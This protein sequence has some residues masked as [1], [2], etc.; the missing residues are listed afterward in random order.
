MQTPRNQQTLRSECE[1]TGVGYWSGRSVRVRLLPGEVSTGIV[2]VRSDLPGRPACP[3]HVDYRDDA[4][5]RTN[6]VNGAARFEM[7]EH[8]LAALYAMRIDNC[9]VEIDGEEFPGLD[10]SSRAYSDAIFAAGTTIQ[11]TSRKQLIIQQMITLHDGASWITASPMIHRQ[12]HFGYQL[13]FDHPG[14]IPNQCF[15]LVCSPEDFRREVASARTFVTRTEAE[16]LQSSGVATHVSYKDLLVFGDT[17]PIDNR[18]RFANECARH[19]ALDLIGDLALAG[20]E[21]VGKFVSHRGGHRLNGRMAEA[22]HQL[23]KSS[24]VNR[25]SDVVRQRAA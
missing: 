12:S 20:V 23:A 7:V 22:L 2:L 3:A 5:L 9:V 25:R 17:G 13:A 8:V 21:L 10:G 16:R 18:L 6:L 1:I 15:H 4:T 24:S 11:S 19:K 14:V